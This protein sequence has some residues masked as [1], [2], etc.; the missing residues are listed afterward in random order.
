MSIPSILYQ[1]I[2]DISPIVCKYSKKKDII[3]IKS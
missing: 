3:M 1:T 2:A